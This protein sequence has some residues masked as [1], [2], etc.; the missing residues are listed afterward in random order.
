MPYI[1]PYIVRL[2]VV[3]DAGGEEKLLTSCFDDEWDIVGN[4]AECTE[5]LEDPR[6]CNMFAFLRFDSA[7]LFFRGYHGG[8]MSRS[9]KKRATVKQFY[10]RSPSACLK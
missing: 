9:I 4:V 1:E 3:A 7:S 2:K 10:G 8:S 6:S 5:G